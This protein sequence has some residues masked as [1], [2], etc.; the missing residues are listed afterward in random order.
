MKLGGLIFAQDIAQDIGGLVDTFAAPGSILGAM[1]ISY[2]YLDKAR[3]EAL[4]LSKDTATDAVARLDAEQI[5]WAAERAALL[6]EIDRLHKIAYPS[7]LKD[8][9][10]NE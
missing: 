8:T 1:F 10:H 6:A 7:P 4:A 5:R 3:T 2:R 9:N